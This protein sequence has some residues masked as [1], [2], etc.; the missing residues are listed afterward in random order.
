MNRRT[1]C[2]MI[3]SGEIMLF[4]VNNLMTEFYFRALLYDQIERQK[5]E[6]EM[7]ENKDTNSLVGP[8]P[9]LLGY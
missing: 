2:L 5:L 7:L 6:I 8:R 1:K 4:L 9:L 3:I